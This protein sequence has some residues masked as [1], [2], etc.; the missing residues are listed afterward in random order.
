MGGV[1]DIYQELDGILQ[2]I[3][4][5]NSKGEREQDTEN[6]EIEREM[7]G[8]IP[9]L[10]DVTETTAGDIQAANFCGN[11]GNEKDRDERNQDR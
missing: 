5:H 8:E 1:D 11:C 9:V 3:S 4:G 7:S 6:Y 2:P 10:A